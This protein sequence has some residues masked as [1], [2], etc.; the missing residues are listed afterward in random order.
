VLKILIRNPRPFNLLPQ[1]HPLFSE[2]DFSFPSGHATFFMAL[3]LSIFLINKK[4]G[5]PAITGYVFIFFAFLIGIARIV[6]GVHFPS[7]ILSGFI[8]G[9]LIAYFINKYVKI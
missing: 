4:A 9:S 5:L 1:V 3:A 7:D 8:L 6:A 2:H